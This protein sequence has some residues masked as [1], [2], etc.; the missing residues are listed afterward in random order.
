MAN[1][2]RELFRAPG[3]VAFSTAGFVARM[4]ISMT[5]IGII[6]MLSQMRGEYGL[7]GAVSAVFTLSTALFGP[8]V[9]RLA[10][11]AGQG[12]VLLPAT[13]LSV[14]G[15]GA[16]L[17]C[18]RYDAPV[19]TLFACAVLA[20]TLPNMAA[21]VRARWTHAYRGSP[22]LHTAFSLESVVDELTF[23]VGPALSVGLSTAL[24]PEAGPLVALALLTIGVLLFVPQ[25][26]TE[27]PVLPAG[28]DERDAGAGGGSAIR[29]GSVRLLALVLVAGGAIVGTVDV[30]GVAFAEERGSAAGAGIVLSVYAIGSALAGLVF[31]TLRLGVPLPRLLVL[32]AAG[33]ALTTLPLLFVGGVATLAVAVFF[34]GLFFAPTMIVVMNLVERTVPAARLTEGMTWAITGL[35]VGVAL[36]AGVSGALVDRHGPVGGFAVAVV[37]GAAALLLA[38]VSRGPL[39][40]ALAVR[41]ADQAAEEGAAR[42]VPCGAQDRG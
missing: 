15:L 24:F 9:A 39:V 1:P 28:A 10:D 34:A 12:R 20:G 21:M 17:L 6:T 36:G 42:P 35:N 16:L 29:I 32:G 37:A 19:W 38:V 4:P 31:G 27:P 33:T 13:G 3:S 11:R 7:A 2:Y 25:K 30:V 23:V 14:V 5:A 22:R 26:S 18:A 8:Q 40:R 41:P